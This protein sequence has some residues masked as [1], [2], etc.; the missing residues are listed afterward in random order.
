M[1]R[2]RDAVAAILP[3]LTRFLGRSSPE[4]RRVEALKGRLGE[5]YTRNVD[6]LE[7]LKNE[8]RGLERQIVNKRDEY[9]KSSGA[10]KQI[11]AREIERLFRE[12]D[13][14]V[15]LEAILSSNLER[16]NSV[17][18]QIQTTQAIEARGLTETE[19]DDI[20]VTMQETLDSLHALDRATAEL[21]TIQYKDHREPTETALE[22]LPEPTGDEEAKSELPVEI[23]KR[24]RELQ[25]GRG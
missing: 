6:R 12:L 17:I 20:A 16:A 4:Q 8:I 9:D 3:R 15:R 19:V 2:F 22:R 18:R 21:V 11:V 5:A 13:S 1:G 24:L 23:E 14:I 25:I 10:I 7:V